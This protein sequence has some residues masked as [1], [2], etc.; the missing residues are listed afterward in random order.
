[1]NALQCR[2]NPFFGGYISCVF[3]I[4]VEANIIVPRLKGFLSVK[5]NLDD[6]HV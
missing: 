6:K 4:F 1:M 2:E 3:G 5:I